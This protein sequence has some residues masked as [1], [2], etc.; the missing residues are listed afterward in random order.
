MVD[1]PAQVTERARSPRHR[2]RWLFVIGLAV[3]LVLG[4]AF[5]ILRVKLEGEDLG[6]FIASTLN[7]RMRGRIEIGSIEWQ[8]KDLKKV[9][10]GGWIPVVVK[11]VK[12]WDDCAQPGAGGLRRAPARGSERGLH[13]GRAPRYRPG[14]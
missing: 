5:A 10:T 12:V 1:S 3:V 9:V 13:P 2:R 4:A 7:K 8:T 11:D 6:D 14:E